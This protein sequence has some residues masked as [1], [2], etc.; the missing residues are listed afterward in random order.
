MLQKQHILQ[1]FDADRTVTFACKAAYNIYRN[2]P[3]QSQQ[4]N[5]LDANTITRNDKIKKETNV[6]SVNKFDF[7][8][9]SNS[10]EF[11]YQTE[12][13]FYVSTY[14]NKYWN[15]TKYVDL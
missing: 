9:M 2:E 7:C 8:G 11:P 13:K 3:A 1:Q 14:L 6:V 12:N 4:S 15:I 10:L 5:K